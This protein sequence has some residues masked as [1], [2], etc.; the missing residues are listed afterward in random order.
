M[1]DATKGKRAVAQVA[2]LLVA[3]L[4]LAVPALG[5]TGASSGPTTSARGVVSVKTPPRR[6]VTPVPRQRGLPYTGVDLGLF[7]VVGL[8]LIGSGFL[9]RLTVRN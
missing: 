1:V 4:I 7:T 9:L 5:A 3:M 6:G 2:V 8:A